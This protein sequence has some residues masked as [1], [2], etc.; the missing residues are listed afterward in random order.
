LLRRRLKTGLDLRGILRSLL[1][2]LI[3]SA[4]AGAVAWCADWALVRL[5]TDHIGPGVL[6]LARG[7]GPL[8]TAALVYL[9]AAWLLRMPELAM[10]LGR[11]AG[12]DD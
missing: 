8:M 7:L 9:A 2:V 12:R 1:R 6:K 3:A 10:L 11:H 4:A 5:A